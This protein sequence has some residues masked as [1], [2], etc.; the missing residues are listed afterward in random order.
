MSR[1]KYAVAA[2]HV[3]TARAAA[4]ILEQGGNAYDA[5]LAAF[6]MATVSEPVLSSLGGGGFLLART[7]E[8]K[9]LLYDFFTQTPLRKLPEKEVE[10]YP[11]MADF[12]ETQQE[13]HIGAGTIATPGCVKGIFKI[14]R[15]L[16][17]MPL[18]EIARPAI[19]FGRQGIVVNK[20]QS[21]IFDIIEAIYKAGE[22][23]YR[24]F[25]SQQEEGKL[26]REGE[27]LSMKDLAEA[28]ELIVREGEDVFY[29]GEIAQK[30]VRLSQEKGGHLTEDDLRKYQV[31]VRK[32]LEIDYRGAKFLTNSPPSA[33]G[34]LIGFALDI[35]ERT[36]FKQLK[37]GSFS[38]LNNLILAME[39]TARARLE[40]LN[41]RLYEEDIVSQFLNKKLV[42][43]YFEKIFGSRMKSGGTTHM[44]VID[45]EGNIASL[46]TTNGEG[47]SYIIPGTGIMLNNMLGE[48][49]LNPEGFHKWKE[50]RR[51][52]SMASPSVLW[53]KDKVVALGSAGSN[54]I[55]TAILETVVNLLDFGMNIKEAVNSPRLHWEKDHLYIEEGFSSDVVARLQS[56]YPQNTLFSG[57]N[58]YFGGVNAVEYNLAKESFSGSG[59]CRRQGVAIVEGKVI[60]SEEC[61]L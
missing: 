58:L 25:R 10:F 53:Q 38:H 7:K 18:T 56:L 24:I 12:G 27:I 16:G 42:Q 8:G 59:D 6:L 9:N 23:S 60:E 49:D 44:S 34:I 30:I 31:I 37:F 48:E 13:F 52:S 40:K 3:E 20:Y 21:F 51:I 50:N 11:I 35:L 19:E 57:K 26:K 33:G 4:Q 46:T 5:I 14:H 43:L 28:I 15:D 45:G 54:R 55:R 2:G 32:P 39:A 36:D 1:K 61:R 29:R 17:K 47:S 41:G 22:E